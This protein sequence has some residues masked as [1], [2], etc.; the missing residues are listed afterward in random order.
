[1]FGD[2]IRL[3]DHRHQQKGFA[4]FTKSL[5]PPNPDFYLGHT[6]ETYGTLRCLHF[7]ISEH[8]PS[9]S[10]LATPP[11]TFSA[12]PELCKLHN[13]GDHPRTKLKNPNRL[14]HQCPMEQC[15]NHATTQTDAHHVETV[16][17]H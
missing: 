15:V 1:M 13:R 7:P 9:T 3:S 17:V 2:V 8:L 12:K 6:F 14:T 16:T 10:V 11:P 5:P 4:N